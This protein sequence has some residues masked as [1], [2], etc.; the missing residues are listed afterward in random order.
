LQI[1]ILAAA[2][3]CWEDPANA[4]KNADDL[5]ASLSAHE[6]TAWVKGLRAD[7]MR[8]DQAAAIARALAGAGFHT[9]Q[10]T[11]ASKVDASGPLRAVTTSLLRWRP[12]RCLAGGR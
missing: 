4:G 9:A 7:E 11:R 5:N 2:V 8:P 3:R 10:W 6:G 12:P 1:K